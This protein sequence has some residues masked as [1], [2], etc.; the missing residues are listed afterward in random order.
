MHTKS[1]FGACFYVSGCRES[2]ISL[3]VNDTQRCFDLDAEFRHLNVIQQCEYRRFLSPSWYNYSHLNMPC[4][5]VSILYSDLIQGGEKR[6]HVFQIILTLFIFSFPL[7]HCY[8]TD[9]SA[10]FPGGVGRSLTFTLPTTTHFKN[11]QKSVLFNTHFKNM[12]S[13]CATLY[14]SFIPRF[15]VSRRWGRWNSCLSAYHSL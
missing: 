13:F 12:R 14:E 15:P 10:L 1:C 11:M 9:P 2:L 8:W 6:T 3:L 5:S 7:L 4:C